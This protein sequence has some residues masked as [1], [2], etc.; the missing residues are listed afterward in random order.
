MDFSQYLNETSFKNEYTSQLIDFSNQYGWG[1]NG[2]T[3]LNFYDEYCAG[4]YKG[5]IL[6]AKRNDTPDNNNK[7]IET[8]KNNSQY[9]YAENFMANFIDAS[10]KNILADNIVSPLSSFNNTL[11]IATSNDGNKSPI[12]LTKDAIIKTATDIK[13]SA[14]DVVSGI[15]TSVG[16]IFGSLF[17]GIFSNPFLILVVVLI[18]ILFLFK[19][20]ILNV[21]KL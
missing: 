1:A 5:D 13:N 2:E 10:N 11:V 9:D 15:G 3:V 21:V 16:D 12:T 19:D 18:V 4:L 17:K 20:K 6:E 7:V 8:F 14:V